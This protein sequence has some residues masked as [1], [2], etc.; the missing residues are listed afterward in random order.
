MSQILRY[1]LEIEYDSDEHF[2]LNVVS[3]DNA[4]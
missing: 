4:T 2:A 1:T 3:D